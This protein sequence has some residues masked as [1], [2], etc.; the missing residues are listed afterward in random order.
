MVIPV[1]IA[2]VSTLSTVPMVYGI[3]HADNLRAELLL[4]SREDAFSAFGQGRVDAALVSVADAARLEGAKVVTGFCIAPVEGGGS[5]LADEWGTDADAPVNAVWVVRS[6]AAPELVDALEEAVTV[7]VER[8]WEA[9]VESEFDATAESY[10]HLTTN[11]DY[12][13]D[14]KKHK[15]ME[16][17]WKRLKKAVSHANPG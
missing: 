10:G 6:D 13:L 3:R 7:G 1:K 5:V 2:A 9:L 4:L 17:Y 14:A 11:I 8:I 15:A 16:T 12:L